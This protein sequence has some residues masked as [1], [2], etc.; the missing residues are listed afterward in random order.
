MEA[1][2]LF[3]G[4]K[5]IKMSV[6]ETQTNSLHTVVLKDTSKHC[7]VIGHVNVIN[8]S[9]TSKRTLKQRMDSVEANTL[10]AQRSGIGV[11]VR[12]CACV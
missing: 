7:Y 1:S 5:T 9:V 2:C 6:F 10:S 12:V 4:R 11:C 8:N 3:H